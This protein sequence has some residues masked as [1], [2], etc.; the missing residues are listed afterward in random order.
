MSGRTDG[1]SARPLAQLLRLL[2]EQGYSF[3][4]VTPATHARV[5]ERRGGEPARD[6]RDIFG[7][8]MAFQASTLPPPMLDLLRETGMVEEGGSLLRSR[9]RVAELSGRLF[10]HSAYP[11]DDPDAVF[12]GPDTYRFASFLEQEL[13]EE[14]VRCLVDYGAGSGVGGLVAAG[15]VGAERIVLLDRNPAALTLANANAIAAATAVELVQGESLAAVEGEIDLV[16][17]NPPFI[18][19]DSGRTYRDGG[20]ELGTGLSLQ[21]ARDALARLEPGGR[22]L[23]YTGSPIVD[24]EDRLLAALSEIADADDWALRYA[25]IDPD[26]FGEEL[27]SPAYRQARVERIAAVGAV[28]RR[29]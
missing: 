10:L 18:V 19:D 5:L 2:D 7:W 22:M 29:D 11:T 25:E 6:L 26:I 15:L 23:L 17:A 21:W 14:E 1:D 12:F 28:I 4:C 16:I 8:S 20:D 3:T 24:G 13:G 27:E 9:V